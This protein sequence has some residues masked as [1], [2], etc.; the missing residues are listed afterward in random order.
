MKYV[1]L[2]DGIRKIPIIF[3]EFLNH[4]DIAK[5]HSE[6]KPISAGFITL[7][8]VIKCYG[9]SESLQLGP[10]RYDSHIIRSYDH[11]HGIPL[12]HTGYE[13]LENKLGGQCAE[14]TST[15]S[16]ISTINHRQS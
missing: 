1:I 4:I 16:S 9:F 7:F 12:D 3:P 14:K 8:P 10:G 2:K 13:E 6:Y 15:S 5:L 11:T